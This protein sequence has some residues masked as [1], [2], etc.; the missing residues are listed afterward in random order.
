MTAINRFLCKI[1]FSNL[2]QSTL[3]VYIQVALLVYLAHVGSFIPAD[4]AVIGLT[5][6]IL[7]RLAGMEA[8]GQHTSSFMADL[9]Q[10]RTQYNRKGCL[11]NACGTSH[12][13]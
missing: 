10:V 9:G 7:T 12:S 2:I 1:T 4:Y 5:D 13:G 11:S 3:P 6:R 8:V